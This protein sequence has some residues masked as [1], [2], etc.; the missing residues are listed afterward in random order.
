TDSG[1]VLIRDQIAGLR[2]L[3]PTNGASTVLDQFKAIALQF[4]AANETG[5]VS[6]SA[7]QQMMA[8]RDKTLAQASEADWLAIGKNWYGLTYD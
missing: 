4:Q 5:H 8:D 2:D 3:F 1:A 7:Y 6:N